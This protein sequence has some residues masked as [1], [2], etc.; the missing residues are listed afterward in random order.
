MVLG[1]ANVVHVLHN[2]NIK[3]LCLLHR[4][5]EH[6]LFDY[7]KY[8]LLS[9]FSGIKDFELKCEVCTLAKHHRASSTLSMS[10]SFL[11]ALVHSDACRPSP[12]SI[13]LEIKWCQ[14]LLLKLS[15][16]V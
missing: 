13:T 6:A 11:F 10:R 1:I 3:H 7:L 16:E 14:G 15:I 8:M 9:L 2:S 12:I 5:L 4:R